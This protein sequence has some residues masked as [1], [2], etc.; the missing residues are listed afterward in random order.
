M[1]NGDN[2]EHLPN[3]KR[4]AEE[5]VAQA[6]AYLREKMPENFILVTQADG[7]VQVMGAFSLASAQTMLNEAIKE[8]AH[9]YAYRRAKGELPPQ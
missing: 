8:V 3:R 4:L 5:Q 1:A 6:I 2:V 7:A 9:Q